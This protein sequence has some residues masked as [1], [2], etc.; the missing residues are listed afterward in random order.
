MDSKVAEGRAEI[1][2]SLELLQKV[3]RNKPDPYMHILRLVF[4]AKADELSKIFSDSYPEE[5][6]RVYALLVELDQTNES[7]YKTILEDNKQVDF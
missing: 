7:K 2:S 5:K 3:Y 1:G 6:N 4:D